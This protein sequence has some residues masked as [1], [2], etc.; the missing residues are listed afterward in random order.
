MNEHNVKYVRSNKE[1]CAIIYIWVICKKLEKDSVVYAS[2]ISRGY[3]DDL[4]P[5]GVVVR[6]T[7][8]VK[9]KTERL[10]PV[11]GDTMEVLICESQP[12]LQRQKHTC[13]TV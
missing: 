2:K 12:N 4:D 7:T 1:R 11:D 3:L 8:L 13:N 9:G 10:V 5:K 6:V